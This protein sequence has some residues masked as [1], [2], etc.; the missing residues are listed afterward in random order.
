MNKLEDITN[1]TT[2]LETVIIIFK[3]NPNR[4]YNKP[5]I[6][7][8]LELIRQNYEKYLVVYEYLKDSIKSELLKSFEA[9]YLAKYIELKDILNK[10]SET[11][12]DLT[13]NTN[14]IKEDNNLVKM[15][16]FDI[17]HTV[18]LVPEFNGESSQLTNFLNL[19]E[20][21]NDTLKDDDKKKLIEF[22]IKT[23]LS[24][25]ARKKIASN[26][27][28]EDFE[29]LRNI[30][31]KTFKSNRSALVVQTELM[32]TTQ[33]KNTLT[34]Y[35]NKVQ[36]L[37]FELSNLQM[38]H[39]SQLEKDVITVM[40]EQM[41]SNIFKKGLSE[42]IRSVVLSARV[43]T[44]QNAIDIACE[45][46]AS[47]FDANVYNYRASSY[48]RNVNSNGRGYSANTRYNNNRGHRGNNNNY[49]R[50]NNNRDTRGY[51]NNYSGNRGYTR[52]NNN[53]YN[54][55]GDNRRRRTVNHISGNEIVVSESHHSRD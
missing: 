23:K 6:L 28:I 27:K 42:P 29:Q 9:R 51:S 19:V 2:E 12:L 47:K 13:I 16:S 41:A 1:L 7:N 37:T 21:V 18:K 45:A 55:R 46:E 26:I 31:E 25:K 5:Y 11:A 49:N 32:S 38:A 33:G 30:F 54:N 22:V 40:N 35:I 39:R 10:H 20:Y 14:N 4:Q 50:G 43:E 17:M 44:L 48:Q 52:G 34:S 3:K 24:E 53:N 15:A 8:K 36:N